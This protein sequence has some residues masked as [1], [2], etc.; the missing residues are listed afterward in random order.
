MKI[1][2]K[3]VSPKQHRAL[4]REER[5]ERGKYIAQIAFSNSNPLFIFFAKSAQRRKERRVVPQV[6]WGNYA[7]KRLLRRT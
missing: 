7:K 4:L 2:K 5:V 3:N 6:H 1:K